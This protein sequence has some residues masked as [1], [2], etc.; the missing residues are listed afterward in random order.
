[1]DAIGWLEWAALG[2]ALGCGLNMYTSRLYRDILV[3]CADLGVAEKI[4]GHW[5][6]IVPVDDAAR[7]DGGEG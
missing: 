1:M 5:Y 2:F 4:N 6:Y 3:Q 7:R